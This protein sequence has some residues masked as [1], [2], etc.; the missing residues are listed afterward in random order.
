M[1]KIKE[2]KMGVILSVVMLV[3]SV[4]LYLMLVPGA[5][6]HK[7]RGFLPETGILA[8]KDK[9]TDSKEGALLFDKDKQ[10]DE[11]EELNKGVD[12]LETNT[13]SQDKNNN[14]KE[15]AQQN[16]NKG[17]NNG[18]K[19]ETGSDSKK[20]LSSKQPTDNNNSGIIGESGTPD[21]ETN[22]TSLGN[23]T[24]GGRTFSEISDKTL[25]EPKYTKTEILVASDK[26]LYLIDGS[27]GTAQDKQLTYVVDAIGKGTTHHLYLSK[28]KYDKIKVGDKLKVKYSLYTNKQGVEFPMVLSMSKLK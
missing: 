26:S 16:N 25:G 6:K 20:P 28:E 1:N 17:N 22:S 8:Q 4:G 19:Q 2:S 21:T 12:G 3:I 18:N 24:M 15:E 9:D 27:Y 5:D 13:D 11:L 14:K 7:D 23:Q 10:E